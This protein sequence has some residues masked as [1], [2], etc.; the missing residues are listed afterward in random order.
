MA[1]SSEIRFKIGADTS[2][3]SKAFVG[4]QSVAAAAGARLQ[5]TFGLKDAMKGIFQGIGIGSVGTITDLV[6]A[7][8]ERGAEKAKA[9]AAMTGELLGQTLR[10][11]GAVGGARKQLEQQAKQVN[12]LNRDIAMQRQLVADLNANPINLITPG[13]RTA[14][15]EAEIGL[16]TLIAKQAEIATNV[17]IA[18]LE[19]N[20]RTTALQRSAVSAR[21]LAQLQLIDAAEGQKFAERRKALEIETQELRKQGALPSVL[22][23]NLNAISAIR[24]EEHL[25]SKAI[26]ERQDDIKR[27]SRAQQEAAALELADAGDRAKA[28][29]K[30]NALRREYDVIVKRKGKTSPEAAEN[31]MQQTG[32]GSTLALLNKQAQEDQS[33]ALSSIG[34]GLTGAPVGRRSE[35]ERIADRGATRLAQADRAIRSGNSPAFVAQLAAQANRDFKSAGG[36]AA[37][38]TSGVASGDANDLGSQL[39]KA[40]ETL[41]AI[42]KNLVPQTLG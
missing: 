17:D 39:V 1:A 9:M 11:I 27:A 26:R 29:Q 21:A 19:E 4:A 34:Q 15:T 32:L 33:G 37:A 28:Q 13:G 31:R 14:I 30:L 38:S 23:A 10:Y 36:K 40:N 3:L 5:K 12:E 42:E 25:Y 18:V 20:R 7:P 24:T 35:R 16:N 41:K 6:V 2:A 8:F 22:Q